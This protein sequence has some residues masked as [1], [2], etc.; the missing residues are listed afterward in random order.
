MLEMKA[1]SEQQNEPKIIEIMNEIKQIDFFKS[2][3][4]EELDRV[5]NLL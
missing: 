3:L 5:L 2:K 4:S 1:A